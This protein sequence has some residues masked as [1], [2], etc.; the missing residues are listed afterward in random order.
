MNQTSPASTD[1]IQRWPWC[2]PALTDR[3]WRTF[4]EASFQTACEKGWWDDCLVNDQLI[5]LKVQALVEEKVALVHSEL[6]E[7]L[8][9]YRIGKMDTIY[10][11]DDGKPEGFGSE[12]SDVC[13][14]WWDL[15]GALGKSSNSIASDWSMERYYEGEPIDELIRRAN[16]RKSTAWWPGVSA[17]SAICRL[18][19]GVA[20][21]LS[22]VT[23]G[24]GGQMYSQ[25]AMESSLHEVLAYGHSL[26]YN[27]GREIEV[28]QAFNRTRTHR[29]GGKR[30]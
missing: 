6:S 23:L 25:R 11:A 16:A 15:L 4:R 19:R 13:I 3:T 27:M 12:L 22:A 10:R 9:D 1:S 7:A 28:K 26:G 2:E 30:C 29:H 24:D 8:E 14:R 18:H 5:L 20:E 17:P 21:T